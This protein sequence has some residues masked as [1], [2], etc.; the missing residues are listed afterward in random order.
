MPNE[1]AVWREKLVALVSI[2]PY[3][4]VPQSAMYLFPPTGTPSQRCRI[5]RS[6]LGKTGVRERRRGYHNEFVC[7]RLPVLVKKQASVVV[8]RRWQGILCPLGMKT[9]LRDAT[10]RDW[11][12]YIDPLCLFLIEDWVMSPRVFGFSGLKPTYSVPG[13]TYRP[14]SFA[15]T[16]LTRVARFHLPFF[17]QYRH[18]N[19]LG[20]R[21]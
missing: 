7:M 18:H 13:V 1:F 12:S 6:S 19:L 4:E 21:L 3:L 20:V 5:L 10:F 9:A 8:D 16:Y 15:L 2:T 11:R 17:W 14:R